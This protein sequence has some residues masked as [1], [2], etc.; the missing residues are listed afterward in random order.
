MTTMIKKVTT[1]LAAVVVLTAAVGFAT[2]SS[3]RE[4]IGAY[5]KSESSKMVL[6]KNG[7]VKT[8]VKTTESSGGHRQ[9][10]KRRRKRKTSNQLGRGCDSDHRRACMATN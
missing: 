2:P 3:A 10:P 7:T 1:G 6:K 8:T 9:R 5:S 4:V